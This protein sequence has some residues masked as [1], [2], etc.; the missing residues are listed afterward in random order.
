MI[1]FKQ[2]EDGRFIIIDHDGELNIFVKSK[3][4]QKLLR[5][6]AFFIHD[7]DLSYLLN[8]VKDYQDILLDDQT[9]IVG[10]KICFLH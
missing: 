1:G 8:T 4:G 5:Q 2:L 3:N 9:M 10:S 7:Y 6:G